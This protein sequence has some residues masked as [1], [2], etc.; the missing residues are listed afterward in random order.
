[1]STHWG[2]DKMAAILHTLVSHL[3]SCMNVF[4]LLTSLIAIS[5][6]LIN[7]KP[8][9][10]KIMA[11][12]AQATGHYLKHGWLIFTDAYI[13][14]KINPLL[15]YKIVLFPVLCNFIYLWTNTKP[16]SA[17]IWLVFWFTCTIVDIRQ[18]VT[19]INWFATVYG[20]AFILKTDMSIHHISSSY[21][22]NSQGILGC[23][24]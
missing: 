4:A 12:A 19:T 15:R 7:N 16:L 22:K 2:R 21:C 14:H 9:L 5:R 23:H 8:P 13:H 6:G 10:V 3:F 11:C 18:M 24:W 1:M 17:T 20:M